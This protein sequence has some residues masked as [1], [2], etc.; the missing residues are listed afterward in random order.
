MI[1]MKHFDISIASLPDRENLVAEISYK[2]YQWAELS[3]EHNKFMIEFYPHPEKGD[4]EFPLDEAFE[5]L[6]KAKKKYQ[7][8]FK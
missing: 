4:W 3:N 6:E 7:S 8:Y 1:N 2:G 5:A